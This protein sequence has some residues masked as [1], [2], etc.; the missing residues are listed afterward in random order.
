MKAF[1]VAIV[2]ETRQRANALRAS[3]YP[4][5]VQRVQRAYRFIALEDLTLAAILPDMGADALTLLSVAPR[6][7]ADVRDGA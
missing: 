5:M 7:R 6:L 1:D 2:T 4:Q 3:L